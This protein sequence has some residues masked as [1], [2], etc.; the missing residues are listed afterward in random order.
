MDFFALDVGSSFIKAA[1]LDLDAAE[2][3]VWKKTP[4]PPFL[5]PEHPGQ[6]ALSLP[7]LCDTVKAILEEAYLLRPFEGVVFSSQM[8]G[9]QLFSKDMMPVGA[10]STWQ[11]ESAAYSPAG[12]PSPVEKLRAD[13]GFREIGVEL[14]TAHTASQLLAAKMRGVTSPLYVTSPADALLD[15]LTEEFLPTHPTIAH[16][17]GLYD[18]DRGVWD[19]KLIER[20]GLSGFAFPAIVK[21]ETRPVGSLTIHG[22]KVALFAPLGDQ[23]AA[24]LGNLPGDNDLLLNIATGSQVICLEDVSCPGPYERR[25]YFAGRIFRTVTHIPAGRMLNAIIDF[26]EDTCLRLTGE[27]TDRNLLWARATEAVGR[28]SGT[29]LHFNTALYQTYG[30]SSGGSVTGITPE[31]LR[32]DQIFYAAYKDVA[33]NF[34]ESYQVMAEPEKHIHSIILTGGVAQRSP[35]LARMIS[36]AFGAEAALSPYPDEVLTGLLRFALYASGKCPT[37]AATSEKIK[38]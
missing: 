5:P 8:H 37:L 2:I 29:T 25:P 24:V 33:R 20:H 17:F 12:G 13:K 31:N 6:K 10:C 11:D 38:P 1:W 30:A 18:P 7:V 35:F 4:T 23:Q 22:H 3:T 32:F 21:D 14:S 15:A 9:L 19:E 26:F 27:A 28:L 16:A 34:A 36:E